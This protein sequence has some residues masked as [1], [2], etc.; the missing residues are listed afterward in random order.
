LKKREIV[1]VSGRTVY[2]VFDRLGLPVKLYALKGRCDGIA[3]RRY[4][5]DRPNA[6]WHIDLK[7]TR[8]A[9]GT[10]VFICVLVDDYSRY[11]LA[12]VAGFSNSSEWVSQVVHQAFAHAGQPAELV[13]DNGREFTP[14]WQDSLTKF[15]QLLAECGIRHLTCAPYYPQGN[16]K[17]EAFIKTLDRECLAG[18]T[19]DNLADVQ[20]ALDRY[21]TYYNNYRLHSSLGWQAPV[22]RYA[23]RPVAARGLAGILGL[24]LMAANPLC[25]PAACDPPVEITPMT[26][27]A[28]RA[29]VPLHELST[30]G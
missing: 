28:S 4:T 8:L 18:R 27:L 21:L 17:A 13:S 10:P 6:Q 5:K 1:T 23:G 15:G 26:A 29:L 9:D 20:A 22:T 7:H 25:G 12:A 14:V 30:C 3:Y 16:G 19:F 24:E 11:A 2:Q